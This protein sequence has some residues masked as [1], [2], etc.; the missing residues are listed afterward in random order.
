MTT[1]KIRKEIEVPETLLSDDSPEK[2]SAA[3]R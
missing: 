3:G 2:Q 1:E